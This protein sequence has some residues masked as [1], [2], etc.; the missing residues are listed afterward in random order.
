MTYI[1]LLENLL[2]KHLEDFSFQDGNSL[3]ECDF[4]DTYSNYIVDHLSSNKIDAFSMKQWDSKEQQYISQAIKEHGIYIDPHKSWRSVPISYLI[5]YFYGINYL[6]SVSYKFYIQSLMWNYAK[7]RDVF[8][9]EINFLKP[10]I[11]SLSPLSEDS[12]IDNEK[13]AKFNNINLVEGKLISYFLFC[14]YHDLLIS[15]EIRNLAKDIN[16]FFWIS[17]KYQLS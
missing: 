14:I 6:N 15:E 1:Y 5:K 8:V 16:I 9:K 3:L 12:S 11:Y 4:L 13:F 10:W 7:N 2:N 17:W